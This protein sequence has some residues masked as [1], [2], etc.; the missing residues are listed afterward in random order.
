MAIRRALAEWRIGIVGL[1]YVGLTTAAVLA[2]HGVK[3]TGVDVDA[4]KVEAINRG[5]APIYEPG[6]NKLLREAIERGTLYATTSYAPL[7]EAD[8]IFITVGTP[9]LSDGSINLG[10]V[11]DAAEK[12]ADAL[13]ASTAEY[14]V[15]AVK[16]TVVPGTT[17]RVAGIIEE[18]TGLHPG[19]DFG[20]ASNPEFLREGRAV[21]DT[22]NPSRVVIGGI[23]PR[24]ASQL[25]EFW[26]SFY[27]RLGT[28]PPILVVDNPE[29]AEMIKYASNAFLAMK[30]SF[31]NMLARICEK[32]TGCDIVEVVKGMARDPR[33]N[34]AFLGAGLGY[35]GSCFP[36]DVKALT[37][38]AR[39]LCVEPRLLEAID[40]VNETQP[41][42]IAKRLEE[43]LNTLRGKT[44]TILGAAFKPDTDDVR[45]SR[46]LALAKILAERGARVRIHDP[47]PKALE[48][49]KRTLGPIAE[50]TTSMEEAL[51][52]A[53]AAVIA[54]DW[55][56]YKSLNPALYTRLMRR[57]LL[58]DAR[59]IYDP[60]TMK[61]AGVEYH[62]VGLGGDPK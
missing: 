45:E 30:I 1:G 15:V 14:P 13:A 16:S 5:E 11:F 38:H 39:S 62:A 10:Y 18:Q 43:L 53:D 25:K 31:A 28:N 36:K 22:L 44:V 32:I 23:E 20:A 12:L 60:Q 46:A 34:P 58:F 6:L 9:S 54:T 29:T 56:H 33:I 4:A 48:N 57:P 42:H 26:Q 3:V 61:K 47:N 41:H 8:I 2:Y 19:R 37:A 55:E 52:G 21:E 50:Y 7:R 27:Q 35:G 51:R 24:S 40:W 17:R 49:A 59:R